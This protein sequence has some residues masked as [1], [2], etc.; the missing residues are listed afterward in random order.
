MKDKNIYIDR[1][2]ILEDDDTEYG[3]VAFTGETLGDFLDDIGD[4]FSTLEELNTA[5]KECGIKPLTAS[6]KIVN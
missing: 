4:G 6:N 3:G 5:L 1:S 2:I